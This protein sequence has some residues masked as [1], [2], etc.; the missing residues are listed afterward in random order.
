ME[1]LYFNKTVQ[2]IHTIFRNEFLNQMVDS[3]SFFVSSNVNT[4]F[5]TLMN[6]EFTSKN[7]YLLVESINNSTGTIIISGG[8][9][10]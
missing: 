5:K 7:C 10:E 1:V 4:E 2:K 6:Y 8:A 3:T 9:V